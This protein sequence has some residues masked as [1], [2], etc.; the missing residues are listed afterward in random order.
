VTVGVAAPGV[1]RQH[2]VVRRVVVHA[3]CVQD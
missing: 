2:D 3:W 1:R